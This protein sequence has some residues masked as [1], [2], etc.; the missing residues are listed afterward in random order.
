[1]TAPKIVRLYSYSADGEHETFESQCDVAECFP[2]DPESVARARRDLRVSGQHVT[3]GGAAPLFKMFA[4]KRWL[5]DATPAAQM[6][7]ARS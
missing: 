2:D 6:Q 7:G 1:M 3:G 5:D 4:R